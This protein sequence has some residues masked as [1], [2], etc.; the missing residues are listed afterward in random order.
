MFSTMTH[1]LNGERAENMHIMSTNFAKMLVWK[2]EYDVK[3]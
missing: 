1:K 2:D 3:L